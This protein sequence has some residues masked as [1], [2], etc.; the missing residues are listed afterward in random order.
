MRYRTERWETAADDSDGEMLE[1][2]LM[3]AGVKVD[4]K[5]YKGVTHEFLG[6]AAVVD[7]AQDA[8]KYPG[9]TLRQWFAAEHTAKN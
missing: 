5:V 9:Q 3:K 1:S 4:R 6:T 8:Q 7:R 2:A